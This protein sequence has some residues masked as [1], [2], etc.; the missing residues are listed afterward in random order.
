MN[1]TELQVATNFSFLRG[2]MDFLLSL[3]FCLIKKAIS[4]G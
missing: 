4:P 3:F 1:Y 2:V